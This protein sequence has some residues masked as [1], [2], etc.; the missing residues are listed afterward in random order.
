MMWK[1]QLD[2][3]LEDDGKIVSYKW[4]SRTARVP[5][6]S[7][8]QMLF[9]YHKNEAAKFDGGIKALFL[10]A[11]VQRRDGV[12]QHRFVVVPEDKMDA[13]KKKFERITSE[14]IYSLQ[15]AVP[16]DLTAALFQVDMPHSVPL[17]QR[18]LWGTIQCSKMER[19]ATVIEPTYSDAADSMDSSASAA[20]LPKASSKPKGKKIDAASFFVKAKSSAA[21]KKSAAKS[22]SKPAKAAEQKVPSKKKLNRKI[23]DDDDDDDDSGNKMAEDPPPETARQT[24]DDKES[25]KPAKPASDKADEADKPA[26]EA[27]VKVKPSPATPTKKKKPEKRKADDGKKKPEKRKVKDDDSEGDESPQKRKKIVA[28]V[29]ETPPSIADAL[30]GLKKTRKIV[31][32]EQRTF[33]N[34]KGY[35]VTEMVEVEEEVEVDDEPRPPT[36]QKPSV[37][38]KEVSGGGA[39]KKKQASMM[40]FF[41]KK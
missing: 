21:S 16:K 9:T 30:G 20:R 19:R 7:A 4:L 27:A 24:A 34:D 36:P 22:E 28:D 38:K 41:K 1:A 18:N 37:A 14:H 26:S 8:K 15:R 39:K 29:E 32:K 13:T 25:T 12:E 2:E 10:V 40:S 5:A 11:G 6:N 31:R 23:E 35:M 3:A 17:E 33:V